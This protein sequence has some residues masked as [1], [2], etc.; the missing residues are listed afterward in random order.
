MIDL[1]SQVICIHF[2]KHGILTGFTDLQDVDIAV[3]PVDPVNPV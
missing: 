2:K 3:Y 1:K